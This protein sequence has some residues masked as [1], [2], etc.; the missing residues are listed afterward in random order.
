MSDYSFMRSGQIGENNDNNMVD[1]L[2]KTTSILKILLEDSVHTAA[3][4][5]QT[6]NRKTIT[7][8]DIIYAL[9]YE[10][11]EFFIRDGLETRFN[12]ALQEE[13]AHTYTTDDESTDD[14]ITDDEST[15]DEITDD[16]NTDNA[17]GY[18]IEFKNGGSEECEFHRKV[19]GYSQMWDAWMPSDHMQQFLK[20]AVDNTTRT[21]ME[22]N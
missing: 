16:E 3:K 12:E 15:D 2:R 6:C 5:T 17:D 20:N 1:F 19:L 7:D 13:Q 21:M 10:T 9:K 18:C 8:R 4:F 22:T 14:E 11:H